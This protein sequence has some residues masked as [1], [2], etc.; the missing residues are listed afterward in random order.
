M[1]FTNIRQLKSARLAIFMLTALC[2]STSATLPQESSSSTVDLPAAPSSTPT[3]RLSGAVQKNAGLRINRAESNRLTPDRP[4]LLMDAAQF[5][6]PPILPQ[7]APL[8]GNAAQMAGEA[9]EKA[10]TAK[11]KY[12]W[13]LSRDGGYYDATGQISVVVPG[14]QLYKYGGTFQDGKP[15][16]T[17]P[18][19]TNFA[20]HAYRFPYVI[21]KN[22]P[23]PGR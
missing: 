9:R 16:P 17:T 12:I 19:V 10:P 21:K 15:V 7:P 8:T 23:Q 22:S 18:V 4:Y 3:A 11:A 14:D 2:L 1:S 13:Q 6:Q 20:N 5:A